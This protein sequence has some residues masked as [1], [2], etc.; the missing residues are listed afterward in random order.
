MVLAVLAILYWLGLFKWLKPTLEGDDGKA[1]MKKLI[2]AHLMALVTYILVDNKLKAEHYIWAF[3]A[4]LITIAV[5]LSIITIAQ[6]QRFYSTFRG[7][8]Q[9]DAEVIKD[10]DSLTITKEN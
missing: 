1:S 9:D 5:F 3:Y 6:L 4:C 8:K 7:I 10:G 2:P